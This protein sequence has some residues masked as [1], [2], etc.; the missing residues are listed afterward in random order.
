MRAID[1]DWTAAPVRALIRT[2]SVITNQSVHFFPLSAP[3]DESN[4]DV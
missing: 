3:A 4:Y 1:R 2:K